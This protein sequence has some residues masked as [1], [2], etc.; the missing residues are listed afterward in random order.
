[1]ERAAIVAD[2]APERSSIEP[3]IAVRDITKVYQMGEVQVHAL[4]GI[5][6]D[7]YKGEFAVLLGAASLTPAAAVAAGQRRRRATRPRVSAS[8]A[9]PDG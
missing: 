7:L 9:C 1:M 3:V 6:L 8:A 4:R 5:D 2:T